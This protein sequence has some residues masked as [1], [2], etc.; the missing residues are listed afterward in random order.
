MTNREAAEIIR[1][2]II[3]IGR[4]NGKSVFSEAVNKLM[5]AVPEWNYADDITPVTYEVYR[6][7]SESD[8][9][10]VYG[11]DGFHVARFVSY[12]DDHNEIRNGFMDAHDPTLWLDVE[13]WMRLPEE[14]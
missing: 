3:T 5:D 8:E 13:A 4:C 6:G 7:K 10:L 14:P 9:V 1:N 12:L 2:S 11:E